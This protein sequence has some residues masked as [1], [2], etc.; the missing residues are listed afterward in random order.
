[1]ENNFIF[2]AVLIQILLTITVY[3]S[4]G[5]AKAKAIKLN[6]V[7]L[8]R[9]GMHEDA[10]P[11]SVQKINNNIRSQ[12]EVPI[13]FYIMVFMLWELNAVDIYVQTVAWGF[14]FSRMIHSYI[15]TGSNYV[16]LRRRFFFVGIACIFALI[17]FCIKAIL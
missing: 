13:L 12:F 5:F 1:M 16:P 8:D 6:Q 7:N 3:V 10:W 14:V 2:L 11:E 15:H 17:A 9:R 4:L